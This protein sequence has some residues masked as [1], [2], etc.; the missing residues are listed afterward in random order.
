MDQLRYVISS[1]IPLVQ[2]VRDEADEVTF[3]LP[4]NQSSK[5]EGLFETLETDGK[6]LG[7]VS[8]GVSVTTME[9][10]FLKLVFA[11]NIE[12]LFSLDVTSS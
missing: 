12:D 8:F 4:S 10:V 6:T 1:Q 7:I 5:F 11:Q 2:V 3:I 9:E